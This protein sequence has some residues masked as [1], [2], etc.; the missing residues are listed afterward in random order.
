MKGIEFNKQQLEAYK[1]GATMFLVPITEILDNG[2]SYVNIE[3]R[4]PSKPYIYAEHEDSVR[5]K[6]LKQP[7]NKFIEQEA[8]LQKGD[9]FFI[10]EEFIQGFE[11]FEEQ[12]EDEFKTWYKVDNDL[13]E[14]IE[15][16]EEGVISPPWIEASQMQE[17][18]ARFKDVVLDVEAKRVQ[19]IFGN[20]KAIIMGKE[21]EL[22]YIEDKWLDWLK[23]QDIN[24]EG[25]YVFIYTVK[26]IE[27]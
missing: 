1:N 2:L 25:T 23:E 19:D 8:P 14:W 27:K 26:G 20:E 9:E 21:D 7:L 3:I 5:K 18:Q 11:D 15:F 24:Q 4:Q 17:H 22:G 10:Q 16:E 13:H 6:T 12:K